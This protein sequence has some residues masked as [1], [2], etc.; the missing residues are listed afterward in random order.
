MRPFLR[1]A[2]ALAA[3]AVCLSPARAA[4]LRPFE[5]A[6][7]YALQFVDRQEGWAA[8]ADG[9]V[10]HTIDGGKHWER[11]PTGTRAA[12]RAVH[13][14]NPYTGWAVG[15]EELPHDGG[16]AGVVLFTDDGG[17]KWHRLGG[18]PLPGL[19][20]V[21]FFDDRTGIVAGDGTDQHPAGLFATQ[22][23][24]RTWHA[25]PGPRC[26]NWLAADFADPQTGV[27]AGAWGRLATLREGVFNPAD[28]DKLNG[29]GVHALRLQGQ[30]AVA[31]GQGGLVLR[32]KDSAGLRWGFA[33]LRLPP[34]V[35]A[36]CD[37]D[38][39]ALAGPHIW[40]AGRPGSVVFHSPDFGDH[41]EMQ[42]TGS[43]LPIHALQFVDDKTGWAV[44]EL[45]TVL[46]TT[47][48]G[49]TWAAQRR[50]GQ[51]AAVLLVH[52]RPEGE[53]LE[54]V[55]V[56]GAE[57]GYLTAAVRVTAADPATADPRRASDPARWAAAQRK[58]GG[59]AGDCLA[60]FPLP[61]HLRDADRA[62][63]LAA[64]DPAHGG[65]A[66]AQLVRQLVLQIRTWQPEVVVADFAGAPPEALVVDAVREAFTRA[67][68]PQA[69]PELTEQFR[70]EPW[71]AKKL[72]T[73]WDGPGVTPAA[74]NAAEPRRRLG[75]APRDFAAPAASLLTHQP[76]ELP[77]RRQFRL[78]AASLPGAEQHPD[79]MTGIALAPGGTARRLLP[80]EDADPERVAD[81]ER[82]LRDRRNL[83]ALSQ[84][85]WGKLTD[86][87]ALL[88]QVGP[89]VAKLPPEQGAVAAYGVASRYA[90]AGQWH[91]A[92]EA[93]L[94]LVDRFPAHPLAADAYRW[95]INFHAS[96]EAR[97]REELGQFLVLTT[98]DVRQAAH[99]PSRDDPFK[100]GD[101]FTENVQRRQLV[102]LSDRAGA[103]RWYQGA[104]EVE[105]RLTALGT[106]AA[107]DPALQLGLGAARRQLGDFDTPKQWCR[108]FLA[109]PR[110]TGA[111]FGDDP[112]REA[113]AAELW[114]AERSGPPPK[115][116]AA[117]RLAAAKPFLDGRLDDECWQGAQPLVL[118]DAAGD[119]AAAHPTRAWL[120]HD[121]EY[122]YVAVQCRHP[123][124]KAVPPVAKRT[125]D[126]DLARF[127]RVSILLDLDRDYQTY[128]HLQIDQ[129]GAVAEDCWGDRT[130]DPRWFVASQAG[131]EGWTAE[132]AIPLRELTGD[133][134]TVG[135]AWACNVVRV[136]PGRGVQA[137]SLPADVRPR[138]EGMG[139][140]LFTGDP[141][142]R[143]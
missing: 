133:T 98:N 83:Q 125:R 141:K 12:L 117:C 92:R 140:L 72:Y 38:A 118:L 97:R 16:S 68:D 34:E 119:T 91:L 37:F 50:G 121:A 80:V 14:V 45:G 48:G 63:L 94:L 130:W 86:S 107:G 123:A 76:A 21:R 28:V 52:A 109:Q 142:A 54:T 79:L 17:L 84:P 93:Y 39:V 7:L 103:R 47:D 32:S 30:R 3:L 96:S 78:L 42:P 56:L 2:A 25:A 90:Q 115:P 22:D 116:A 49:Q 99:A 110:G 114:L 77:A 29:R 122:L 74:V 124:G 57:E 127:D 65:R 126:A 4:D 101:D 69:F 136:L 41:W 87:G 9:V 58:A 128:F 102:L 33:D 18:T 73:C 75:E 26:P 59:A 43:K 11:Q 60:A 100:P 5:D 134:P 112:W 46:A 131:P 120:A 88:A 13:F 20:C 111:K 70:L 6:P 61:Q 81:M 105:P 24:G 108:Q 67:A 36:G 31:A 15:R 35:A 113:A 44:G 19:Y 129:R 82:A 55:A 138:P 40:V 71:Q 143:P 1:T 106:P 23:G 66:A 53:P 51:R 132:A 85:D 10:W 62:E 137:W 104:L 139:L 89:L 8:G 27:L 95:L 135:K 64:W